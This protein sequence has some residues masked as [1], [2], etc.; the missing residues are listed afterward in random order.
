MGAPSALEQ[1][2]KL[3]AEKYARELEQDENIW[4]SLP[5]L[6]ATLTLELTALYQV[7]AHLGDVPSWARFHALVLLILATLFIVI[8][9]VFAVLMVPQ[10]RYRFVTGD[11]E[12]LR[13][14]TELDR[15]EQASGGAAGSAGVA[16]MAE[17]ARQHALATERNRVVNARRNASR[18]LAG[19]FS[20][21]AV[22]FTI[23]L[24]GLVFWHNVSDMVNGATHG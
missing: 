22:F 6:A 21:L 19:L 2:G 4:R 24:V 1:A 15:A 5:F 18:R 7:V 9:V 3:L 16:F 11:V 10:D 17:M 20:L 8:G 14:A 12:L 23:L 13:F